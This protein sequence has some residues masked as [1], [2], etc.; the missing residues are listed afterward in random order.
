MWA[1]E[2]LA[3]RSFAALRTTKTLIIEIAGDH[4]AGADEGS[5]VTLSN[6]STN[7]LIGTGSSGS[8]VVN[9][10]M[11]AH[12]DAYVA[13][14]GQALHIAATAGVLTNDEGTRH[15]RR[16]LLRLKCRAPS[17]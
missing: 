3:M 15:G 8:V 5:S 12:D 13:L 14:Q 2:L 1:L 16:R 10:D 7:L 4:A 11:E 6:P 9:D 17:A